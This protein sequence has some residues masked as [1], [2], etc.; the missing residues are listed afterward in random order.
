MGIVLR[1]IPVERVS[2]E[3]KRHGYEPGQR[4]DVFVE[5]S[6]GEIAR[7]MS[8]RAAEGGLTEQVLAEILADP[9]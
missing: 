8:D 1:G 5:E 3:L 9:R 2:D 6:F 4:V 7:R